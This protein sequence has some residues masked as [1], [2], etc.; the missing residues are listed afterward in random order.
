MRRLAWLLAAAL[1][2]GC[3]PNNFSAQPVAAVPNLGVNATTL[4]ALL[5]QQYPTATSITL[6]PMLYAEALQLF[7]EPI[8]PRNTYNYTFTSRVWV[9]TIKGTFQNTIPQAPGSVGGSQPAFDEIKQI[10]GSDTGQMFQMRMHPSGPSTPGFQFHMIMPGNNVY[11]SQ[12]LH[13]ETSGTPVEGA[14]HLTIKAGSK[15]T[16]R[17]VR[18]ADMATWS[19]KLQADQVPG[20]N[21]ADAVQQVVI[22]ERNGNGTGTHTFYVVKDRDASLNEPARPYDDNWGQPVAAHV[23]LEAFAR[24]LAEN[25]WKG[26]GI[27]ISDHVVDKAQVEIIPYANDKWMPPGTVLHEFDISGTFPKY[28]LSDGRTTTGR[29]EVYAPTQLKIVLSETTPIHVMALKALAP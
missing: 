10:I 25:A 21:D 24:D 20:M 17:D 7:G 2:S 29:Y 22:E 19:L 1:A 4:E 16:E 5:R 15:Q 26:T 28:V 3:G 12:E 13:Y 27:A 23:A 11:L 18:F 6:E 9:A 8:D 14:V